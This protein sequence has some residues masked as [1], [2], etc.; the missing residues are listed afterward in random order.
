MFREGKHAVSPAGSNM[1][2]VHVSADSGTGVHEYR[3]VGGARVSKRE[4][5]LMILCHSRR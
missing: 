1:R 2:A 4:D 5:F 3:W